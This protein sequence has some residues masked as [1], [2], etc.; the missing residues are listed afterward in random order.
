[1]HIFYCAGRK[2]GE[3]AGV[4]LKKT[5]TG[6]SDR[7]APDAEPAHPV[8]CQSLAKIAACTGRWAPDAAAPIGRYCVC[9]RASRL[10]P[11][12]V[13]L[14]RERAAPH[15]DSLCMGVHS[16]PCMHACIITWWCKAPSCDWIH[17]VLVRCS[18]LHA[19]T[20]NY[21]MRGHF[22]TDRSLRAC[23]P[24]T[25]GGPYD[26]RETSIMGEQCSVNAR[27]WDS[28]SVCGYNIYTVTRWNNWKIPLQHIYIYIEPRRFSPPFPCTVHME[29]QRAPGSLVDPRGGWGGCSPLLDSKFF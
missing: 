2:F 12:A 4:F 15:L 6:R 16:S 7:R 18:I 3:V 19:C 10:A 20:F 14:R 17:W 26:K 13:L 25:G 24:T 5:L 23:W 1:M 22:G 27:E 11:A 21:K 9:L 8:C 28:E 29:I